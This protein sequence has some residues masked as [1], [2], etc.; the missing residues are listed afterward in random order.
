MKIL[1]IQTSTS[2][3]PDAA[4]IQCEFCEGRLGRDTRFVV[5]DNDGERHTY[6]AD[7]H[8]DAL[9]AQKFGRPE[10]EVIA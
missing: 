9:L 6:H 8:Q 4:R 7:C 10:H 2:V 5:T 3:H 1:M